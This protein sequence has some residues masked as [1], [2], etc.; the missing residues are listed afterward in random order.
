MKSKPHE[1]FIIKLKHL[2]VFIIKTSF[3]T[4]YKSIHFNGGL[5]VC[6]GRIGQVNANISIQYTISRLENFQSATNPP[7]SKIGGLVT[8]FGSFNSKG[9]AS[10]VN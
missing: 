3:I 5:R 6:T 9:Y 8:N 2:S 4:I 7:N 1:L 10:C